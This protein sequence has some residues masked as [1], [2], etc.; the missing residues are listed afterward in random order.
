[1]DKQRRV[2]LRFEPEVGGRFIEV[3]DEQSGEGY[4][5]GRIT[6]W[7]PGARLGYTWRQSDWPEE[8]VTEVDVR[9]DAVQGG[10]RVS[11]RQTGFE[12]DRLREAEHARLV[13]LS[14]AATWAARK[15]PLPR[16]RIEPVVVF[17]SAALKRYGAAL[18]A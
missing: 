11:V 5:I 3:Y 7:E 18:G 9:F 4:E 10:T 14:R 15:A 2:G 8:A 6:A 12:K 17:W 13:R 1:M 16:A